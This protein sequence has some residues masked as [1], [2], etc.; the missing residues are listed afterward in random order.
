MAKP[1][2][3]PPRRSPAQTGRAHVSTPRRRRRRQ[4]AVPDEQRLGARGPL[5]HLVHRQR[6]GPR[7]VRQD[8]RLRPLVTL[9]M[10]SPASAPATPSVAT[11]RQ[12]GPPGAGRSPRRARSSSAGTSAR[13]LRSCSCAPPPRG[14]EHARPGR[15]L[16]NGTSAFISRIAYIT[17]SG[18]AAPRPDQ[19]HERADA[20]AE[21][22]GAR[23]RHRRG[24]HVRGH[25]DGA[26]HEAAGEEHEQR[27]GVAR[28]VDAQSSRTAPR[29]WRRC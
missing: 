16:M 3:R 18:Q 24:H 26:E 19:H 1:T 13:M 27:V 8:A 23:L 7:L 14:A 28:R 2:R 15:R 25:V 5:Q 29:R 10:S 22:P 6:D 4:R 11:S 9:T 21:D 17:P 12:A 20:G